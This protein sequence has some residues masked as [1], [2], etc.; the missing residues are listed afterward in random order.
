MNWSVAIGIIGGI[1]SIAFSYIAYQKGAKR[2]SKDDGR[3]SGALM[4]DVGYIKAGVDDLKR[5]QEV[6]DQRHYALVERVAVVEAS[7]KQA[8]LRID[9]VE[10]KE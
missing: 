4:S 9:K 5:K 7:S 10:N 3:T 2:D 6:T 8:H 1:C